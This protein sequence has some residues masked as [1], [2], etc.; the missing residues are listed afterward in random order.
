MS[1]NPH[2]IS[3]KFENILYLRL[4]GNFDEGSAHELINTL[5][6][7]DIGFEDIFIDT[8]NIVTVNPFGRDVFQKNLD[9]IKMQFKNFFIIGAN[10][11]KFEQ[12]L[13]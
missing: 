1:S 13:E 3:Y 8:N 7:H 12:G 11:Y 10:K 2:I 9:S 4:I 6:K 5:T